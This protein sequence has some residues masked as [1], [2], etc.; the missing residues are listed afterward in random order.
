MH[1]LAKRK[2]GRKTRMR[3]MKRRKR[4]RER[5]YMSTEKRKYNCHYLKIIHLLKWNAN[6]KTVFRGY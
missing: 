3:M 1:A 5:K 4:G 6:D 2:K